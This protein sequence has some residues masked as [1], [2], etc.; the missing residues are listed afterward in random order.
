MRNLLRVFLPPI[1]II[2][3]LSSPVQKNLHSPKLCCVYLAFCSIIH[4]SLWLQSLRKSSR[5]EIQASTACKFQI[6]NPMNE[7]KQTFDQLKLSDRYLIVM[8]RYASERGTIC[9]IEGIR[10]G[11]FL[12]KMVFKRVRGWTSRRSLPAWNFA[13]CLLATFYEGKNA[14]SI[15]QP[16]ITTASFGPFRRGVVKKY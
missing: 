9:L 2:E 11:H 7:L 15:P 3:V 8:S 1:I 16:L 6:S 13:E 12:S 10:M 14:K 5:I 4:P